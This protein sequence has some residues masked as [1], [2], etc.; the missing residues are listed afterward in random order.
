MRVTSV[1]Y[2]MGIQKLKT[3]DI[4]FVRKYENMNSEFK[5]IRGDRKIVS[6]VE[7]LKQIKFQP[8]ISL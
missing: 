6:I 3:M 5:Y 4:D 8:K 7:L 1:I 2:T